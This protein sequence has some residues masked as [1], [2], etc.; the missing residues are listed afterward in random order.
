MKKIDFYELFKPDLSPKQMLEY[1][2]FGGS[3]LGKTID[4]Y[5]NLWFKKAKISK[6]FNVE[7][8]YFQIKAGLSLKEWEKTIDNGITTV[9]HYYESGMKKKEEQ[10]H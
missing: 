8:N 4:E 2:V 10:S 1:G 5:P 3:Y 6:K 7:L 9:T